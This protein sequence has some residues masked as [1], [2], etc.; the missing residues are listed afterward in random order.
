MTTI[1]LTQKVEVKGRMCEAGEALE[2]PRSFARR[3]ITQG[4]AEELEREGPP[5]RDRMLHG[6]GLRRGGNVS[7]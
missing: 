1:V 2:V 3:L 4:V 7:W 5:R 6:A